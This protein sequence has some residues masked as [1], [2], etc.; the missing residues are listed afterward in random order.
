MNQ[1]GKDIWEK[2]P[3]ERYRHAMIMIDKH[4]YLAG[5]TNDRK[6]TLASFIRIDISEN[7]RNLRWEHLPD[8]LNKRESFFMTSWNSKYIIV[9]GGFNGLKNIDSVE[10]YNIKLNRWNFLNVRLPQVNGISVGYERIGLAI[11][12]QTAND[13]LWIFGGA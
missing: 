13:E 8:M 12:K 7:T 10:L 5:G 2:I 3:F 4:I 6:V 1:D 9:A 11:N